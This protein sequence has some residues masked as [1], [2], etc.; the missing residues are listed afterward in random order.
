MENQTRREFIRSSA[1]LGATLAFGGAGSFLSCSDKKDTALRAVDPAS[2]ITQINAN[3]PRPNIVLINTDDMGYGDLGCYGSRAVDTPNIDRL[4]RQGIRF[5]DAYAC[6][7]LCSPSR[8]GLLTGRYPQRR[9]LDWPIWQENQPFGRKVAKAVGH[10]LGKMGLTD[11]GKESDVKGIPPDEITI[12]EA[13]RLAGYRTALIGKWHL[14]D[15]P[16]LPEYHPM[17]H[18]FDDFYGV[19]YSN[20]MKPFPLYRGEEQ[21]EEDIQGQDQ[22]KLTRLYTEEAVTF[23]K[24]NRDRPFFLYL[25]HTFPHRPIFASEKFRNSSSGGLYG[26][27]VEEIDWYVGELMAAL[28]NLGLENNTL[29]VFTSD[30]G[31]WYYGSS[32]GLRGGKGQSFEGGFRVPMIARWPGRIPAGSESVEPVM[33][34]DFYPTLLKLAGLSNPEDRIIDGKDIS[35]L[36]RGTK[37]KSPHDALFFYHHNELEAVRAGRWKYYRKINLYKYPVPVNKKLASLGA[38]KLG[39]WP[40]L[41]DMKLDPGEAYNLAD[42]RSDMTASMEKLMKAWEAGLKKNPAGW[43]KQ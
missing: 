25:A 43:K 41:Y 17:K 32:G 7:A 12:G 39:K 35:G 2:V 20:G 34:F 9:G 10:T 30:N 3:A 16:N 36:L 27:V 33:N 1:V 24:E 42:N 23:M 37:K 11:M 14:G 4:A 19:P 40:L 5:T 38:G 8:F 28:K 29:V 13:L 22:A 18:G 31:P 21:L 15:F 6:N 26:D